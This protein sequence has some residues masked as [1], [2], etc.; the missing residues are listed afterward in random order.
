MHTPSSLSLMYH[1]SASLAL[2]S[3]SHP[4]GAEYRHC[5]LLQVSMLFPLVTSADELE[6]LFLLAILHSFWFCTVRM[7]ALQGFSTH[8]FLPFC[9]LLCCIMHFSTFTAW[10]WFLTW[11]LVSE[12][13]LEQLL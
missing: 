8:F 2:T 6:M 4:E 1:L 5:A 3:C 11:C 13:S 9:S 7:P 10:P 12:R